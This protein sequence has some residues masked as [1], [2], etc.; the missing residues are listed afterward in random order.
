[1][2]II[3]NLRDRAAVLLTALIAI[4]LIGFLVQDAFVGGSRGLFSGRSNSVGSINGKKI[5]LMEFNDKVNL[6][7][8]NYRQRGM[9]SN[10]MLT[11]NVVDGVWNNYIQEDL[12]R[13][14]ADKL[15]LGLTSKEMGS[16]LFSQD[17]P[18]EF[19]QLFQDPKTGSFDVNAAKTWFT[20]LKK[21]KKAE[22]LKSVNEQLMNPL[23]NKL[24]LDKYNALFV[25]GSYVPKWMVE[26]LNTDNS[27]L[28]SISYVSIPYATVSDSINNVKIS[29]A[30]INEYV[31]AHKEDFKQEKGR[32]V[33]YVTFDANPSAADS[34][35]ILS[36]LTMLKG[37]LLAATD[38]KAFVTR[39]NSKVPFFDGFVLKNRLQ[40]AAKDSLA[41]L[42]VGVVMGPYLDG[43]NYTIARKLETRTLPDSVRVRHI[44][45]GTVDPQTGQAKRSDSAAKKLADSVFALVKGGG[46]FKALA[47]SFSEDEGSKTVGGEYNI[48]SS[49]INLAKEFW[50]FS[51]FKKA[52]DRDIVKTVFGYH[53][54]EV[55]NQRN[56]EEAY[57]I[58]YV[59]KAIV[60]S[61]ETDNAASAAATQFSGNSRSQKGFDDNVTKMKLN[62]RLADNIREMDYAVGG[63]PSRQ[64]VKWIFDNNVGS[65]SEPFD[66]KDKYV[67]LAVTGSYEEGVQSAAVARTM[68]EP[69]LRNRKKAA[70]IIS[71]TAGSNTLEA[72]ASKHAVQVGTADSVRFS[73]A[74]V[75]DLG[76]EPKVIGASFDKNN[77]LKVSAPIEGANGVYYVQV[78]SLGAVSNPT[79]IDQ[80]RKAAEAQ[81]RQY[82]NFSSMEALR[83]AADVKDTRRAAGY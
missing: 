17:A 52:G 67:V 35:K 31:A 23:V 48:A 28:A 72:I 15:G 27:G 30:E 66:L 77:Q 54:M 63:M 11:Q 40:M 74:F 2:S 81:I 43:G 62:K 71:K 34:A 57:K 50:D 32:S 44:L 80:L 1:M 83:K 39:N 82:A 13:T 75:R 47:A 70:E 69:I 49:D 37:Q 78:K 21:S 73:E 12:I 14:E 38:P 45:I 56:Y 3:Q 19:K 42:P 22:D 68:V 55:L 10:E 59:A 5:D 60:S 16:L 79:S 9:Q 58:A 25:Q 4:S 6:L 24:L 26:K 61:P 36:D 20:N 29:D 33:S 7:E 65:V 8:Q 46:D 51:F 64:M 53:I 41:V 76:S 18:Q